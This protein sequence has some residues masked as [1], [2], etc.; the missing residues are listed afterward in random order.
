MYALAYLG[1]IEA[2]RGLETDCRTHL[3]E[4][5]ELATQFGVGGGLAYAHA[6]L[7]RLALGLDLI[8]E[9]TREIETATALMAQHGV[10]EPNWVQEAPDLIEAYTRAG[11]VSDALDALSRFEE[12]AVKTQR[13]WAL[14]AA[15]RCRGLLADARSFPLHFEEALAWHQR[16][17]TPFERARTELCFAERLR[18]SG[19]TEDAERHLRS[20][21][22]VFERLDAAP[23]TARARSALGVT[24][25]RRR[26]TRGRFGR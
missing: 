8:E 23:W 14:A 11:R 10:R 26:R 16:S 21:L 13:V 24:A 17:P 20:A 2:G 15:A 5:I 19:R 9:A 6:F 4:L 1:E 22:G 25:S 12:K 18:K 7:G 3:C